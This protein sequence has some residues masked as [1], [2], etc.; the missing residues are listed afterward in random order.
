MKTKRILS[1]MLALCVTAGLAACKKKP[2]DS[3]SSDYDVVY[4]YYD[5][6][7][8][9]EVLKPGNTASGG[10][11]SGTGSMKS[12]SVWM[13]RDARA[14]R[15]SSETLGSRSRSAPCLLLEREAPRCFS[16]R[17]CRCRRS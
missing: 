17:C 13:R 4:E 2:A 1:L 9:G 16:S 3:T 10:G 8:G 5:E 7:N 15:T 14:R 11:T 12:L 6:N